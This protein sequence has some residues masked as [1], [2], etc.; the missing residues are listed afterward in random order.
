MAL[1]CRIY[2]VAPLSVLSNWT[3][4]ILEHCAGSLSNFVYYDSGRN[5]TPDHLEKFDVVITTY[6]VVAQDFNSSNG[7]KTKVDADGNS[8]KRRKSNGGLFDVKWK[9]KR[10]WGSPRKMLT[11][12]CSV[13]YWTKGI[14]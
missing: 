7:V 13:L 3:T 2:V 11:K 9:V 4:Q 1:I 8:K 6:Q 12:K 10:L 14:L 5:V